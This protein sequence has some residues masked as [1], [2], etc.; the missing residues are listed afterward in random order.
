M[1]NKSKSFKLTVDGKTYQVDIPAPGM[2]SVDGNVFKIQMD[3]KG[4]QVNDK[5]LVSSLSKDFAVVG[6]KLYETSWKVE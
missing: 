3:P 6:G 4:V 5:L 2:I 1:V